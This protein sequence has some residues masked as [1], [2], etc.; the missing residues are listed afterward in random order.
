LYNPLPVL[1]KSAL[2]AVCASEKKQDRFSVFLRL[3]SCFG[4]QFR[5]VGA[6][7]VLTGTRIGIPVA[8]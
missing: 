3:I 7:I 8:Q 4:R 2:V 6:E 5:S 1:A